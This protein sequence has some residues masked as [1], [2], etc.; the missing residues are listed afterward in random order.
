MRGIAPRS[1]AMRAAPTAIA[2][3][4]ADRKQSGGCQWHCVS[5]SINLAAE[6]D[7]AVVSGA[8]EDVDRAGGGRGSS[9]ARHG[10]R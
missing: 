6:H 2:A 1:R 4:A 10:G 5:S 9:T 7:A 8:A 3:D